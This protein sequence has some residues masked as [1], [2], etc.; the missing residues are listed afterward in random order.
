MKSVLTMAI[1]TSSQSPLHFSY[2]T[3]LKMTHSAS[4]TSVKDGVKTVTQRYLF[5]YCL[6]LRP[7]FIQFFWIALIIVINLS[8]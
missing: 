2:V 4:V 5:I 8:T 3:S 1:K 6:Y 7:E